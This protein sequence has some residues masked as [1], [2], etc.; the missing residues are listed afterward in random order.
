MNSVAWSA[1]GRRVVSGSWD[2]TIRVWD[3]QKDSNSFAGF[4]IHSLSCQDD[5]DACMSVLKVYER[6][7]ID[8]MVMRIC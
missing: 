7:F 4:C 2:K 1:D 5:F 3:V 8:L 6:Y